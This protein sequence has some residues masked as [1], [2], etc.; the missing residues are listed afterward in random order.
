[1]KA[2]ITLRQIMRMKNKNLNDYAK[3]VR[4]TTMTARKY[5]KNP[6]TMNAQAMRRT[7]K[8]LRLPFGTTWS[9]ACGELTYEDIANKT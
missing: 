3:A 9:L 5:L 8:F 2:N 6:S 7:D 4:R 1:M